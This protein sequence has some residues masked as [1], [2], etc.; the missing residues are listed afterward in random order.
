M[1]FPRQEYWS[2]LPFPSPGDLPDPGIESVSPALQ[3]DS[4]QLSHEGQPPVL[5]EEFPDIKNNL[6]IYFVQGSIF[7]YTF[8]GQYESFVK[9]HPLRLITELMSL[10]CIKGLFSLNNV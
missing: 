2:R 6:F 7:S 5:A 8:F 4:L 3:A 10:R 9:L 1:R